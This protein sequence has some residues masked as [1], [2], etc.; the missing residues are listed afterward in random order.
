M[1]DNWKKIVITLSIII[2]IV[3]IGIIILNNSSSYKIEVSK[4]DKDSPARILKVFKN[5]KEIKFKE[6]RY[7]DDVFLCRDTN[8]TVFWGDI[9]DETELKVYLNDKD[10]VI[11][12][13][14]KGEENEKK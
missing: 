11:A 9:E 10:Y 1:L 2:V 4:V 8:P 14:Y 12:K 6:I 3:I 13:I 5:N 7:K